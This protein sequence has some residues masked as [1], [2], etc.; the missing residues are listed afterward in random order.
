SLVLMYSMDRSDRRGM[1]LLKDFYIRRIF[2]IYP[3][4]ILAVTC[5]LAL[6][7]DSDINGVAGLSHGHAPGMLSIIS[8][9]L[10]VQNL[11]HAKS[12]VNVLWSLP[13]E[14]Q[15]YVLLPFLF[16]WVLRT[17][18]AW[19]LLG[20][21]SISMVFAWVQPQVGALDHLA[22]LRFIP[23]FLPGVVA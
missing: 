4:S 13:F 8:Q 3:L 16:V 10:L 6:G 12:V 7:L 2:R 15:M 22:L 9:I 5:A 17:R 1:I 23:C 18:T 19:R 21:W 20:L 14:V 11:I